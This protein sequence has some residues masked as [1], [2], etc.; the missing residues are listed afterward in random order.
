M[1]RTI[2]RRMLCVAL[3]AVALLILCS[4]NLLP[5]PTGI[6]S[7]ATAEPLSTPVVEPTNAVETATQT[8]V[9]T[10]AVEEE[11][12]PLFENAYIRI[13]YTDYSPDEGTLSLRVENLTVY[14]FFFM[15]PFDLSNDM[16]D[17]QAF[18][19]ID[20]APHPG[21]PNSNNLVPAGGV[22]TYQIISATGPDKDGYYTLE[23]LGAD[24]KTAQFAADFLVC[25]P[26]KEV[27]FT[28]ALP[29]IDLANAAY[30]PL[31]N[32]MN[33]TAK[34]LSGEDIDGSYFSAH[35]LTMV[36]FWATW[37]GPCVSE[38]PDIAALHTEYADKGFAV[39]GILVWDEGSEKS[40]L[41]FL[42]SSGISY[43]VVA[44]D[45]VPLF[46][47]IAG[48]QQA[49]P[50]TAFYDSTGEQVGDLFVGSR[51]KADWASLI[52]ELL[53]QVG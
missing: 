13:F 23:T 2:L 51:S 6:A 5:I 4:C 7:T 28:V 39:L 15:T 1:K 40:A 42:T 33:F 19:L 48:T 12:E 20:D 34:T 43:P 24:A 17:A 22:C 45:T 49:I 29:E 37:C 18:L 44:Y 10:P 32:L 16:I 27:L 35:K 36:N 3:S 46:T 47:E 31:P 52:D 30:F 50:F 9:A 38:M 41:D 53:L 26:N 14:P 11:P 8:P 21:L 25:N